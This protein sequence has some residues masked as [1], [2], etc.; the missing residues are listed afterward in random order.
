MEPQLSALAA[1]RDHPHPEWWWPEKGQHVEVVEAKR[2]CA[3]CPVIEPCLVES[4]AKLSETEG[5]R[6]GAGGALRRWLR[7]AFVAGGEQWDEAYAIH[8]ARIDGDHVPIDTNGP[9]ACHGLAV[10]YAR[11]CR[12]R[13]CSLAI[14]DRDLDLVVRGDRSKS[15]SA[16]LQAAPGDLVG[17]VL[18]VA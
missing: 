15:A 17:L 3:Q 9:N 13:P 8:L 12:C 1:C 6:G 7:R 5:I 10:T 11:G 18:G 14:G 2:V 4:L 16:D